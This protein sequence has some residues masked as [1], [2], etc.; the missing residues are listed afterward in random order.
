MTLSGADEP[1]PED[2]SPKEFEKLD[3]M[4]LLELARAGNPRAREAI[5]RRVGALL[6]RWVHGRLP[7]QTRDLDETEDIVQ[8]TFI[9]ALNQLGHFEARHPGALLAYLRRI[10]QNLIYDKLRKVG[11]RPERADLDD[12]HAD[13]APSPLENAIGSDD[14]RRYEEA[15]CRMSESPSTEDQAIAIR[16]SLEF[17]LSYAEIAEYMGR[18][19]NAARLLLQRGMKRLAKEMRERPTSE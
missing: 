19:E 3:T 10:A 13:G 9:R 14:L 15:L 7:L 6:R 16:L 5:F 8:E 4:K 12:N 2:P 18:T 17:Q 1:D 11:R